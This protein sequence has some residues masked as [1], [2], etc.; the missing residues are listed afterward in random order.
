M[1]IHRKIRRSVKANISFYLVSAVLTAITVAMIIGACATADTL[2]QEAGGMLDTYQVEQAEFKMDG[3]LSEEQIRA[4]EKE[5]DLLL[6]EQVFCDVRVETGAGTVL[7]ILGENEKVNLVDIL[8]GEDISADEDILISRRF[9]EGHDIRIGDTIELFGQE[10]M[11]SGYVA[12]PDYLYCLQDITD[13][14]GNYDTF[15][16]VIMKKEVMKKLTATVSSYGVIYRDPAREKEF[17]KALYETAEPNE[18]MTDTQNPRLSLPRSEPE[19]LRSE[20]V[21]YALILFLLVIV[22][23]SFMLSRMVQRESKT[24]GTLLAMGYRKGEL[25]RHY[26]M[27][28]LIPGGIGAVLGI[29]ISIPFSRG[30]SWYFMQDLEKIPYEVAYPVWIAVICL[31]VPALLYLA[32]S[33][34]VLNG[35]I[36]MDVVPLLKGGGKSHRVSRILRHQKGSFQKTYAVRVLLGNLSRSITFLAG[37]TVA[38]MIILL[39][40]TCQDSQHNLLDNKISQVTDARYETALKAFHIGAVAD[41]ETL[42]DVNFGVTGK[43]K[44]FNLVG[45]DED[46]VLL[47][48]KTLSGRPEEYGKYYMTSAAARYYGIEA[49][50]TF[51]FYHQISMEETTVE[52]TDI[53][54]NDIMLL[55]MTSK[56]NAAEIV[57]VTPDFYNNILSMEKPDVPEDEIL[58]VRDL[59]GYRDKYESLLS[60]TAVVYKILLFAGILI[61]ILIVNLLSSMVIEENSRNISMLKV[62]G[63]RS[64]EIRRIVLLPNHILVPVSYLLSIPF[65][66]LLTNAMMADTIE[67]S[68]VL[69]EIVVRPQT[70]IVY[71]LIVVAAY[72]VSLLFAG[73]KLQKVN[74]VESLKEERE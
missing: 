38:C 26:A 14:F 32:A 56:E 49:G 58:L 67:N 42:I 33:V 19:M 5:Y 45:Y 7:R 18:Y 1:V 11:V 13:P 37:M 10:F 43:T 54:D 8:E 73:R 2:E 74:M 22:L 62:L 53:I 29:L 69:I 68:G 35:K 44:G 65:T 24:I 16:L 41:G 46:N 15:G 47:K 31:F 66:L 48:R 57:G 72:L 28:G 20:F 50:D 34:L 60:T 51:T 12:R 4:F 17:R 71:F 40:G 55:L 64:R 59:G 63:Y 23:L 52:I 39:G 25:V 30:F 61:C 70:L 9:A 6:E 3:V 21:S 36:R 27:Y